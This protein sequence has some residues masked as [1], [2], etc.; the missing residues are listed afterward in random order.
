MQDRDSLA[1]AREVERVTA[2]A[3]GPVPD[4]GAELESGRGAGEMA[5]MA[6]GLATALASAVTMGPEPE[7]EPAPGPGATNRT[8]CLSLAQ[9]PDNPTSRMP[10]H[11]C[12]C[13]WLA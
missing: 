6:S 9:R 11:P 7:L 4:S 8:R 13:G 10:I 12:E 1:W 5:P 2:V 3:R